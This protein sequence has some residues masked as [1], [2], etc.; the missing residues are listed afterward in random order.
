M[1]KT[2]K[3]FCILTCL[4]LIIN[5]CITSLTVEASV[6]EPTVI[7]LEENI[8]IDDQTQ[9]REGMAAVKIGDKWGFINEDGQVVI[10]PIYD[11][12]SNFFDG[13]AVVK[14]GSKWGYIDKTGQVVIPLKYDYAE[15][16]NNGIAKV[17]V[18]SYYKPADIEST[19]PGIEK[20][21]YETI[22]KTGNKAYSKYDSVSYFS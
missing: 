18:L 13:L 7:W 5:L 21:N 8:N 4:I 14:I 10:A 12:A 17:G 11:D 6:I 16:F 19:I 1:K 20:Y 22:D 9:F 15:P 2:K 3:V